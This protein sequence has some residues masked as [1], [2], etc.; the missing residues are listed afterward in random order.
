MIESIIEQNKEDYLNMGQGLPEFGSV[1]SERISY[2]MVIKNNLREIDRKVAQE[3]MRPNTLTQEF[4][5]FDYTRSASQQ[6]LEEFRRGFDLPQ[7]RDNLLTSDKSESLEDHGIPEVQVVD[8][9]H[10]PIPE[11]KAHI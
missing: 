10:T 8:I 9:N 1:V 11:S 4:S 6:V 7:L 3:K 5:L 2:S